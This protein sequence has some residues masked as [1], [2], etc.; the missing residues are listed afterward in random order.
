M[1]T[2]TVWEG[3]KLAT[4]WLLSLLLPAGPPFGLRAEDAEVWSNML[5]RL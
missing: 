5:D 3:M 4:A 2:A 1:A